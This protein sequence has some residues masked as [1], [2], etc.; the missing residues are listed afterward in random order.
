MDFITFFLEHVYSFNTFCVLKVYKNRPLVSC[1]YT[2]HKNFV[3]KNHI[4]SNITSSE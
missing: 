2:K 3:Y 4:A 1:T